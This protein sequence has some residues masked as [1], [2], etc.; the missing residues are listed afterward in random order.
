MDWLERRSAPDP[1]AVTA[2]IARSDDC[3]SCPCRD[4]PPPAEAIDRLIAR[5]EVHLREKM[6][7][8]ML[9]ETCARLDEV[10]EVSIEES[11]S[12]AAGPR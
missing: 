6:L 1:R 8:R 5:R 7:W 12:P 4:L 3:R 10:L 9:Y 2:A 11:T